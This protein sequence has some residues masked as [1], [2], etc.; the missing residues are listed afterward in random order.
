MENNVLDWE[1]EYALFV[2]DNDPLLFYRQIL[3]LASAQLTE[4]GHVWFEINEAFGTETLG[5]CRECGFGKTEILNDFAEK[6]RFC[7]V[8]KR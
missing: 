4:T 8:N 3:H 7:R 5:L 6:P 1:P 2:P